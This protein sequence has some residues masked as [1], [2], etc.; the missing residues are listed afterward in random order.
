MP[1]GLVRVVP[2]PR[3][4]R[5][6]RGRPRRPRAGR[7]P[8]GSWPSAVSVPG[9]AWPVRRPASAVQTTSHSPS[10]SGRSNGSTAVS[11]G[12]AVTGA[13][14]RRRSSCR[15]PRPCGRGRG[16]WTRAITSE[17]ANSTSI[18]TASISHRER[19]GRRRRDGGEDEGAEDDPRAGS[20]PSCLAADDAGQ[21]EHDHEERDLEGDA[22]DQQHP[23]EERRSTRRTR[24]GSASSAGVKPIRT[25]RPVGSTK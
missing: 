17:T 8:S 24:P 25:S 10:H 21:V 18:G 15:R 12:A 23:G 6:A 7:T 20:L 2:D 5:P 13:R 3:R 1:P 19:V 16:R 14:P 11:R 9:T 4:R 22:E